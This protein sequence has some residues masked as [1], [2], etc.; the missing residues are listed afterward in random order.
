MARDISSIKNFEFPNLLNN[1]GGYNSSRDK[2]NIN[3]A[4]YVGGSQ[5]VYKKIN[6]NLANRPGLQR[7][8]EANSTFSEVSSEFVWYTS[9]GETYPMWVTNSTLQ[10]EVNEVWYTIQGS[11]TATR[12]V[13]DKWWDNTLKKDKAVFVNGSSNIYS[14]AGGVTTIAS[15]TV[16]TITKTGTATWTED[17]FESTAGAGSVIINGTTYAY[18]GG[19]GTTTLTGVTPDP[20]G[21]ANGST[22]LSA[23]VTSASKPAAGFPGDFCKVVNNR[24]YVGSYTSRLVYISSSTDYTNFTIPSSIIPGSPNLLTLDGTGKGIAIR[25]GTPYVSFGTNGWV[26]VTFPTYTNSSGVLLEQITPVLLPVA[27]L[28]AAYAHEFID[29]VG[30]NIIYLDQNQQ[31]RQLGDTNNNFFTTYPTLSQEIYTELQEETFTGGNL[32]CIGEFIYITAPNTGTTYLYQ[33]RTMIDPSGQVVSERVWHSPFIWNASRVDEID[34]RVV[35]FSNANPQVYYTWDTDQYYD[36]SPS[37]EELPYTSILA[38]AYRTNNRRQGLTSFDKVFTEGYITPGTEL[39]LTINYNFNG[40]SG[41][42][43]VPI[44]STS[45]PAYLFETNYPSLG[46]SPLGTHPLGDVLGTG[47]MTN[48][49]KFKNINSIGL[50]NVFEYQLI[51]SSE[52]ANDQWEILATATNARVEDEQNSGF[53]INKLST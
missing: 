32:R 34:G 10:V 44:N 4:F 14:W 30:D 53:I 23:V 38:F 28:A 9:W 48:L 12:Y 13:F 39:E 1:F 11:L 7:R 45:R 24:L 37:D 33:N 16:N 51:Y 31:V 50:N 40:A 6:G 26:S 27:N 29:N 17:H 46:D 25:K 41:Q 15:T 20:T 5:N 22:V 19:S 43:E 18:T 42:I 47:E 3:E 2:T 35:A 52:S 8:G 36:D 49:V 21:E